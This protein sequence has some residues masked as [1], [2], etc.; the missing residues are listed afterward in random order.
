MFWFLTVG[1]VST[2]Q[3]SVITVF[4]LQDLLSVI[5]RAGEFLGVTVTE[6]NAQKLVEHLSFE[7]MKSL[8]AKQLDKI[9]G[10]T[11]EEKERTL[12]LYRQGNVEAWRT[13]L[14]PDMAEKF[15]RWTK[16]KLAGTEFSIVSMII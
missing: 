9:E 2:D 3:N 6:E 14:S 15:D 13:A 11:E 10:L 4:C 16:E 12:K 7:N 8:L 5:R 1:P